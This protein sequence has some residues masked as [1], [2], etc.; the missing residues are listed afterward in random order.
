MVLYTVCVRGVSKYVTNVVTNIKHESHL[1]SA[2]FLQK[3][4]GMFCTPG[5]DVLHM[6]GVMYSWVK[7][8]TESRDNGWI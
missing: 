8:G 2:K 5:K 6:D 3:R 4:S 1:S 7:D